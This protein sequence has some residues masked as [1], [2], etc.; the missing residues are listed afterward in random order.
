MKQQSNYLH[1]MAV[2]ALEPV[3]DKNGHITEWGL[4]VTFKSDVEAPHAKGAR[5][6]VKKLGNQTQAE[7]KFAESVMQK[8]LEQA[9]AFREA[10]LT[11]LA[12]LQREDTK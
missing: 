10:M 12:R 6:N 5:I 4:T 11:Q 1:P 9:W 2:S 7:Y 3:F 8:G